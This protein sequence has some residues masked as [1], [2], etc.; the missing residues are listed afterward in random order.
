M[1]YNC[2]NLWPSGLRRWAPNDEVCG[3]NPGFTRFALFLRFRLCQLQKLC[4]VRLEEQNKIYFFNS[5]A[6]KLEITKQDLLFLPRIL[7]VAPGFV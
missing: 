3:S 5:V 7:V 2:A 1:I 6:F 4:L